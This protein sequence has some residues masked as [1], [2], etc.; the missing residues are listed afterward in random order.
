MCGQKYS[1]VRKGIIM[2]KSFITALVLGG[3]MAL[4][5]PVCS[6]QAALVEFQFNGTQLT[7]NGTMTGSSATVSALLGIDS[8]LVHPNGTFTQADVSLFSVQYNGS[9]LT[10][11][12]SG[13]PA[14]LSGQFNGSA[15]GF[16]SLSDNQ[17]MT[18][19]AYP[20]FFGTTNFQFYGSGT[21]WSFTSSGGTA[22]GTFQVTGTGTWTPAPV[23]L[24]A[25]A[26]LF[27]TGL[28]LLAIAFRKLRTE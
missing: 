27:P 15:N 3:I 2:S 21:Q 19:P 11:V 18:F 17:T 5:A 12:S 24:P 16:S 22:P 6:V 7:A 13:L 1:F 25:A 8:S 4:A 28:S 10:A 26:V 23:P 20:S 9:T 14:T